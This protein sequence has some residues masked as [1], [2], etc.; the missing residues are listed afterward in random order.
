M[1]KSNARIQQFI[2]VIKLQS[3]AKAIAKKGQGPAQALMSMAELLW[4][5]ITT[6]ATAANNGNWAPIWVSDEHGERVDLTNEAK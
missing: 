2:A 6:D 3:R 5:D 4:L 1:G